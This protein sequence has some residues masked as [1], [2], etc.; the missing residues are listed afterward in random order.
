MVFL[1]LEPSALHETLKAAKQISATVWLGADA[2]TEAGHQEHL[3]NGYKITRFSYKL[4][5]AT[6]DVIED[7][8]LTIKEHHPSE[9]IWVTTRTAE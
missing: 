2:I 1:L 9:I 8:L 6:L 4:A 3:R 7:S 5:S